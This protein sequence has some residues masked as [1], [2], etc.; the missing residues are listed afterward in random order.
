MCLVEDPQTSIVVQVLCRLKLR[1]YI[2][3]LM[4]KHSIM[5]YMS[6]TSYLVLILCIYILSYVS[7]MHMFHY[8]ELSSAN[9][10]LY[11]IEGLIQDIDSLF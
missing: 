11:L 7:I 5:S 2:A 6:I 1:V 4:L 8:H 3:I 9:L 10:Y